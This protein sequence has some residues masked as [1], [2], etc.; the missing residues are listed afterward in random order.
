[1]VCKSLYCYHGYINTKYKYVVIIV[2][3]A[4][5]TLLVMLNVIQYQYKYIYIHSYC[6][7]TSDIKRWDIDNNIDLV[8]FRA[9]GGAEK[10]WYEAKVEFFKEVDPKVKV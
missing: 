8:Y 5:F 2:Y 9:R 4:W 10:K 6:I 1:M 3:S 7:L